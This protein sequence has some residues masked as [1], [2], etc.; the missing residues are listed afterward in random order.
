MKYLRALYTFL[1]GVTF[2]L[3]LIGSTALFVVV[4]TLIESRT[5]SHRYAAYFTY[6]NPVFLGLLWGFF[7]NIAVSALRRWPFKRSHIPFLITHWGLLM[8]LGGTLVKSYYGTQ[9]DMFLIEGGSSQEI[10]LPN[11][12]G[13]YVEKR[14]PLNSLASY[15]SKSSYIPL[16]A[17][18]KKGVGITPSD[19]P[20]LKIKIIEYIPHTR[21]HWNCWIFDQWAYLKGITPFKLSQIESDFP[22]FIP[23]GGQL[24]ISKKDLPW[25]IFAVST[26]KIEEII[27]TIYLQNAL[28]TVKERSNGSLL[29]KGP[30]AEGIGHPIPWSENVLQ[31]DPSFCWTASEDFYPHLQVTL[32]KSIPSGVPSSAVTIPL[33]GTYAL[34]SLTPAH[35]YLGFSRLEIDIEQTPTLIFIDTQKEETLCVAI[36]AYGAIEL[37][38]FPH[39]TLDSFIAY[40]R[41]WSGYAVNFPLPIAKSRKLREEALLAYLEAQLRNESLLRSVWIPPLQILKKAVSRVGEDFSSIFVEFLSLWNRTHRWTYPAEAPL[42]PR[43]EKVFSQIAWEE[44][45]MEKLEVCKMAF[46]LSEFLVDTDL[47]MQEGKDVLEILQEKQW[48]FLREIQEKKEEEEKLVLLTQYCFQIAK[49]LPISL[50]SEPVTAS[51]SASIFSAYLRV[52][53]IHLSSLIPLSNTSAEGK[54]FIEHAYASLPMEEP[55]FVESPLVMAYEALEPTK[56]LEENIPKI[57]LRVSLGEEKET[58]SLA[59]DSH[60]QGLKW[61]ILKGEYRM[62]FQPEVQPLPYRLRLRQSR[63]INYANSKQPFSYECDLL[64]TDREKER[65]TETTLRMNQVYETWSGYR[66]Y[67]ANITPSDEN[68]IHKVHIVVNYDPARYRLTYPGALILSLGMLLLFW[69]R[70]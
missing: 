63:Q 2:A 24:S 44:L 67:L 14:P 20:E 1:G 48:P 25:N 66:F 54:E 56:K 37:H 31:I 64:V 41:G 38:R 28:L 26:E 42:S 53:Q 60:M 19:F 47:Q 62:R 69:K 34:H 23:V 4:G 8:L 36:D 59:F 7:I 58:L 32:A 10:L 29:F 68:D 51:I 13:I 35:S 12:Q 27:K 46:L 33:S 45:G 55:V 50:S 21:S 15:H 70:S 16:Y 5:E 9:G 40:D 18:A 30:L 52:Y 3:L 61:P 22:S 39:K 6:N 43:L 65:V 17:L 57:S 49:N 11:T